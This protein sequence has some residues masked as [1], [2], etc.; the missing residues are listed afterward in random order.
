MRDMPV[1]HELMNALTHSTGVCNADVVNNLEQGKCPESVEDIKT[2]T[3]QD[4]Y[5]CLSY[6]VMW[7][8]VY[9]SY[10]IK[11]GSAALLD[12]SIEQ[13]WLY[14]GRFL[15][16]FSNAFLNYHQSIIHEF[17][18]SLNTQLRLPSLRRDVDMLPHIAYFS[19]IFF[20]PVSH[21]EMDNMWKHLRII[22]HAAFR[23]H[24][25]ATSSYAIEAR[26]ESYYVGCMNGDWPCRDGVPVRFI[27]ICKIIQ[28]VNK[29]PG[30]DFRTLKND[31]NIFAL[32]Y[33][34][35]GFEVSILWRALYTLLH[36]RSYFKCS[37][38]D[39]KWI[40]SRSM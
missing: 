14:H 7:N 11:R 3:M 25:T 9:L 38:S 22:R 30:L 33:P 2:M 20:W 31:H 32:G 24:T 36:Q 23:L 13:Y 40:C 18:K 19:M 17:F 29:G 27:E 4:I 35:F 28:T 10:F 21:Y 12:T 26:P 8:H 39:N 15:K 1:H 34:I 6:R 5:S 16:N 37:E